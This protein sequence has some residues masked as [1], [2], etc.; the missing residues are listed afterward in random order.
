MAKLH[1]DVPVGAAVA[2]G[3]RALV[4]PLHPSTGIGDA[5]L[6]S[7]DTD[8]GSI[9]TSVAIWKDQ[10][11]VPARKSRFHCQRY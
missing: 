8:A 2:K 5:A 6:F 3:F 11:P 10:P 7:T 4:T 1:D 9:N